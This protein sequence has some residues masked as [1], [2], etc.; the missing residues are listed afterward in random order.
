MDGILD[1][2]SLQ[3]Q[4]VKQVARAST[5]GRSFCSDPITLIKL[6]HTDPYNCVFFSEITAFS[7]PLERILTLTPDHDF[8]QT[9]DR[10]LPALLGAFTGQEGGLVYEEELQHRGTRDPGLRSRPSL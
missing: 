1:S 4:K 10:L 2:P 5:G 8:Y 3:V 6:L 9:H 7:A